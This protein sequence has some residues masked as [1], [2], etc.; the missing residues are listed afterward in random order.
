MHLEKKKSNHHDVVL[1]TESSFQSKYYVQYHYMVGWEHLLLLTLQM[2]TKCK[3]QVFCNS[4]WK[5][6]LNIDSK[7]IFFP[8]HIIVDIHTQSLCLDPFLLIICQHGICFLDFVWILQEGDSYLLFNFGNLKNKNLE[9]VKLS[10]VQMHLMV[11]RRNHH[12]P[13]Q[14]IPMLEYPKKK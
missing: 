4:K 8:D 5:S 9:T 10:V 1:E 3:I 2:V 6:H 7:F 13:G 12:L 14:F 11:V